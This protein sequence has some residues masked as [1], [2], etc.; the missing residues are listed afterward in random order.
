[1]LN[2][3]RLVCYPFVTPCRAYAYQGTANF[4]ATDH[5]GKLSI[6]GRR[7][8]EAQGLGPVSAR[9]WWFTVRGRSS[10]S[11]GPSQRLHGAMLD[12]YKSVGP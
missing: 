2:A 3:A 8:V 9:F 10:H 4:Q 11:H 6:R 7:L 1:M 5:L 12:V